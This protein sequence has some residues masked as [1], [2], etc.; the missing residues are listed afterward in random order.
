MFSLII[1]LKKWKNTTA[2]NSKETKQMLSDSLVTQGRE[3]IDG[4][5]LNFIQ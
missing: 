1:I 4:K 5:S 2:N 3:N